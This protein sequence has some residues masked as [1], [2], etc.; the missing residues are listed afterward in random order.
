VVRAVSQRA[1]RTNEARKLGFTHVVAPPGT[2]RDGNDGS[3]VAADLSSAVA[4]TLG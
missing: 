3:I 2:A 4:A 1:R